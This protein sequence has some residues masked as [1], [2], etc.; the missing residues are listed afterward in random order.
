MKKLFQIVGAVAILL[1]AAITA[2]SAQERI[3]LV[4]GNGDYDTARSLTTP[5]ADTRIVGAALEKAAFDVTL[6][7]NADQNAMERAISDFGQ[8][9]RAAGGRATGL[10][11]FSGH[12]LQA[13]GQNYLIPV[14]ADIR[15][16]DEIEFYAVQANRVLR[17]LLSA[18]NE[19]SIMLLDASHADPF[20]SLEGLEAEGLAEMN[21]PRGTFI[22]FS[23][24]PGT[25]AFDGIYGGNYG[26]SGVFA[27]ALAEAMLWEGRSIE[28]MFLDVRN[29]VLQ[30]SKGSQI[31]WR[32]SSLD[33]DFFL[34]PGRAAPQATSPDDPGERLARQLWASMS[35]S[36]DPI[37]II[38]FL[39]N[40][41]D[42]AVSDEARM[43]LKNA[44]DPELAPP[45][46]GSDPIDEMNASPTET[47]FFRRAQASGSIE[48][49]KSYLGTFP[50]AV[51]A[52]L[53]YKE[54][55]AQQLWGSVRRSGD[56]V[57]VIM[58]L[59]SYPDTSVGG[60]ARSWLQSWLEDEMETDGATGGSRTSGS[61]GATASGAGAQ[62]S[63]RD[64]FRRAQASG[65]IEDYEAYLAEFPNGVFVEIALAEIRALR[66]AARTQTARTEVAAAAPEPEPEPAAAPES[67]GAGEDDEMPIQP[68]T[69]NEV[70][71][72]DVPQIDGKSIA[73][74]I[75]G[76]PQ[77]PPIE[78]LPDSVWKEKQC[79]DCHK[80]NAD[81]L[82]EQGNTYL[83]EVGRFAL[84][85][86]HPMDGFKQVLRD[87]A[88]G[89]C[90]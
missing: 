82:C 65:S 26:K 50:D 27:E 15:A 42:T 10:F 22:A 55:A 12:S 54:I 67:P 39:R 72:R 77:Y 89:G 90:E 4:I 20:P 81:R 69:F 43:A 76:S 74:I 6:L 53:A 70:L 64:Y 38:G 32:K 57:Q 17:Q 37:Q 23:S 25:V 86:Q 40:H 47:D 48:S 9:L 61:G 75:E 16:P 59:R 56:P 68:V 11:F 35:P 18:R 2:A 63:E 66:E 8:Q 88:A 58:F 21:A 5:V 71:F 87:W 33:T 46:S 51:F 29:S 31:P 45:D 85:K 44:L 1:C 3:A 49:Y 34:L 60:T 73:Q 30:A 80:W 28:G 62:T 14:D 52:D 41:P 24:S 83:T 79:T 7:T 19:T 78:G 36:A 84:D 13:N